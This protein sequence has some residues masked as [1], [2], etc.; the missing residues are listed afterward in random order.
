MEGGGGTG[1]SGAAGLPGEGERVSDRVGGDRERAAGRGGG[2][3]GGGAGAGGGRRRRREEA[4]GVCGGEE[5][6]R[7]EGGEVGRAAGEG[8]RAVAGVHG[9][10]GVGD[11]GETAA[12]GKRE[13]GPEGI[14]AAG[15]EG[16]G[17]RRRRRRRRKGKECG[18]RDT[19][20][21]VC[22]GPEE[23][24]SRAGGELFYGGRTLAAGDAGDLAGEAGVWSGA[25]AAGDVRVAE[26]GGA[27]E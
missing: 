6:R 7:G 14:A 16:E 22:R 11:G 23:E 17:E 24:G 2:G 4:G 27:G 1:V 10:V 19:V 13:S 8:E 3:A 12:D 20:R 15:G 9:A 26:G 21:D 25:A 18:R 5:K